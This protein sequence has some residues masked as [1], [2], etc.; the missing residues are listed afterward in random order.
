M[1]VSKTSFD[2]EI[3]ALDPTLEKLIF[4]VAIFLKQFF[5]GKGK[6]LHDRSVKQ[7]FWNIPGERLMQAVILM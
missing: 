3:L 4:A 5:L 7:S 2:Q 1:N 6:F